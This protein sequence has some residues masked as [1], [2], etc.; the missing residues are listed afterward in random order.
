MTSNQIFTVDSLVTEIY[1]SEEKLAIAAA[2]IVEIYIQEVLKNQ[3]E[4]TILLATGNSQLKFL[5]LIIAAQKIDWSRINLL[6]LDEYLGIES[7]N[8]ASFR[9]YLHEKVEKNIN[10]KSFNYLIGDTLEPIEEC[11]RYTKLLDKYPVDLCFL[12]IGVNGHLAF[13]EPQVANFNDPHKVKIV[14]L[15]PQTRSAQ[16]NQGHFYILEKVPKYAFTV[17][18]PTI[19]SAKKILCLALGEKKAKIIRQT[20]KGKISPLCPA[21]ILRRHSQATLL[22]DKKSAALL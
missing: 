15:D 17:T 6:H 12:G 9:F 18:I 13:N 2:K 19:M 10:S 14:K 20:L 11:D 7:K 1:E 16:V 8:P 5:D 3:E 4:A 22:L 21:S